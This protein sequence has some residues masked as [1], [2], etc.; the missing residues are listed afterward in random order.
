MSRRKK[1][2]VDVYIVQGPEGPCLAIDDRR[3]AGP[4]PW[5]GGTVSV[6]FKVP[7]EQIR[8]ALKN[9]GFEEA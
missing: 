9:R 3:V 5:G 8:E 4:K 7:V 1:K 6:R 2:D